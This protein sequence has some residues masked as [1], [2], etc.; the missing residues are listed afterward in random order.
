M[1]SYNIFLISNVLVAFASGFVLGPGPGTL[2][3]NKPIEDFIKPHYSHYEEVKELFSQLENQYPNLAKVHSIGKSTE[4][5]DLLVLEISENVRQRDIGEPMVKYVANMHGDE[6]VGRQLMIY[7]AQYLLAN[8]NRDERVTRLVNTTD[9][10]LMPSLNP[11]GFEKSKEGLCDSLNDYTGREN[12][13]HI[14][15]NRDF[16]DQFQR[17][18]DFAVPRQSE[19]VAM[20][21]WI[22]N[23]PFVLSGNFHGGAVVASYPYDSGTSRAC[24][25]ESKSPDD[26]LFKYLAHI[27]A[28]NHPV[29]RNGNACLPEQFP[30][31]VTNGAKWYEVVGGMQ[32]FN[33]ARSNAFEITFELSCCKYPSASYMPE[34]WQ[35]NKESLIKYLEQAHIGIKGLVVDPNGYPIGDAQIHIDGNSHNITTTNRGEYWRLLLPGNYVVRASAW[36]YLPSDPVQVIVKKDEPTMLNFTLNPV[37]PN[38]QAQASEKVEQVVRARDKYGFYRDIPLVHHNYTAMEYF[39]KELNGSYP[40]IARLYSVGKSVQ[41]RELYVMEITSNPGKHDPNKPEVKYIANM[42]G[43]E[44][45]GR[46]MLLLLL[47]Y[48]CENYGTDE[49][50]TKIVDNVRL[51]VMP[52]MNPD[53]YAISKLGDVDGITGRQNA[54]NV[55]LNRNFPDQYGTT[56]FNKNPEPETKA[57]MDWIASIPFVLSANIHGG[58]LVANYPYDDGPDQS[59]TEP[60]L[61]PDDAV[62]KALALAYSNAHPRMH[63]GQP[64]PPPP[65]K[66][67]MASLLNERFPDGITNGAAWYS[68]SGGMQDYN[69]LHSNAFEITLEIGCTKYPK[70]EELPT[71]WLENRE[72]L[73]AFVEMSRKGIHGIVSSSIGTPIAHAKI[74]IEGI[75]HDIYTAKD[76]D[77]WRLLVPG[78]YTVTASAPG[79]ESLTETVKVPSSRKSRQQ[80]IRQDFTLMRDDN[81][82]WSSAYDFRQLIN[83]KPIYLT[84]FKLNEILSEFENQHSDVAEFKA[85]ESLDSMAIHS[86]KITR[87]LGAPEEKKIHIALVGGLFASQPV[88]REI[89]RR[90][91]HHL[92]TG[93][94]IGDPPIV[95]LLDNA[96][97]HI[98]PGVDPGFESLP[99]NCNPIVNNEVGQKLLENN[100]NESDLVTSAFKRMLSTEDYD[101]IV[102]IF[103]GNLGVSYTEDLNV[104]KRLAEK[105]EN[106]MHKEKCDL[107]NVDSNAVGDFIQKQ[108]HIPV[109]SLSLSCC[110]YPSADKIPTIWRDNLLPL[111]ELLFDLTTGVRVEVTDSAGQP[112]R[113]AKVTIGNEVYG[114]TKNMAYFIKTMLPNIYSLTISCDKYESKSVSVEVK[115]HEMSDVKVQLELSKVISGLVESIDLN[116]SKKIINNTVNWILDDLNGRFPSVSRLHTVGH[117]AQGTVVMSLEIGAQSTMTKLS[118]KPAIVFSAGVGNGA[119]VTPEILTNLATYLVTNYKKNEFVTDVL[120]RFTIHIAPNLYPDHQNNLTCSTKPS[121]IEFPLEETLTPDAQMIVDWFKKI[122]ALVAI[123]LNTGSWHIEIPFGDKRGEKREYKTNDEE[124]FQYLASSYIQHLPTLSL[125]DQKCGDEIHTETK[126]IAHGATAVVGGRPNSL[127]DY[128]YLKTSTLMMD[129]YVTCCS[130]DQPTNTWVDH[131]NSLFKIIYAIEKGVAGYVVSETNEPIENAVISYDD[132]VHKVVSGETGS[133]WLLLPAGSH[134]ITVEAPGYI[135][136][137]KT[138]STPEL[139]KFTRVLF[140]LSRNNQVWGLPRIVFISIVALICMGLVV[141]GIVCYMYCQSVKESE[142]NDRRAYAFSLLRDGTSFFDDDEKEVELFN[143][144]KDEIEQKQSLNRPYYDDDQESESDEASDLEFIKPEGDWDDKVPIMSKK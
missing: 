75:K 83:L 84:N 90:L 127:M 21:M 72:P 14:D 61:S 120:E 17:I 142:K 13:K 50:V 34:H 110:K 52:S 89:F 25:I 3:T 37:S 36:G 55:D 99:D 140:K 38:E 64:C 81:D 123:N 96:V 136:D 93:D 115:E 62:F 67:W 33:Y 107:D 76:G 141:I 7:L 135:S 59:K 1:L 46:E 6:S 49:R 10:F 91:A 48:L 45:V 85:G 24:C 4:N 109:V 35:L 78:T 80:E 130:S 118:G 28:D 105:Y 125:L 113:Q 18:P 23:Q 70:A 32:D 124:I 40:S 54:H 31:G 95:K 5:R 42:H 132:S 63:L 102:N 60:S 114:V 71:F 43:N 133:W 65:G 11:D 128:I 108:Y 15:L 94:R 39:L 29:M 137:T 82:H 12:A 66:R 119:S 134:N 57:V 88:G 117:T 22:A 77:Y 104:Y 103:G 79:Y 100:S 106:S 111:K 26:N 58:A 69:Y 143:R 8:Y 19:T 122:Q 74:S 56:E 47:E 2:F 144:S 73:L 121:R 129:I 44:V 51:H 27:Y 139:N 30:G 131:K 116:E 41:G 9:I 87:N 138:L 16:P 101:I 112:L 86:L 68:V 97:I 98:I 92:I 53:G 20:M 126:G